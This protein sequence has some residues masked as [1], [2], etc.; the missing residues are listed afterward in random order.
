MYNYLKN[1]SIAGYIKLAFGVLFIV[2]GIV[3]KQL[4]IIILG[5]LFVIVTLLNKGGCAGNACS[6]PRRNRN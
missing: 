3:D 5:I 1:F 4:Y 2:T 6:A